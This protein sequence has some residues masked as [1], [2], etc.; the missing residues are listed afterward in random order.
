M[1]FSKEFVD[2]LSDIFFNNEMQEEVTEFK[3]RLRFD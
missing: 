3:E 1:K 2:K